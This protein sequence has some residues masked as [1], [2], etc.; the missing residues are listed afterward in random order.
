M[1]GFEK[2]LQFCQQFNPS[3]K[4]TEEE[5]DFLREEYADLKTFIEELGEKET[6]KK[7]VE[8]EN[9]LQDEIFYYKDS[10]YVKIDDREGREFPGRLLKTFSPLTEVKIN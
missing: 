5:T 6:D 10:C 9:V 2:F 4:L 3:H 7:T 8:F 1:Y